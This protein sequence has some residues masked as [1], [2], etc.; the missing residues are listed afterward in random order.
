MKRPVSACGITGQFRSPEGRSKLEW[1]GSL[2]LG[3]P[4]GGE[5]RD[6][7]VEQQRGAAVHS[8]GERLI[9]ADSG[10]DGRP[11]QEP[12]D[13]DAA[14]RSQDGWRQH[15]P[16]RSSQERGGGQATDLDPPD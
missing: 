10:A 12:Q 5:D 6:V 8:Y 14:A 16:E 9:A 4:A 13:L 2:T 7:V 11:G 1:C 3:A 15:F